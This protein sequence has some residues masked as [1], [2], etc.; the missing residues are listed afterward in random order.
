MSNNSSSVE[1]GAWPNGDTSIDFYDADGNK[2]TI[3]FKF[4][5]QEIRLML[6]DVVV[7]T[8]S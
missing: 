1:M 7:K 4:N 5:T 6:N 2:R 8:W 3:N